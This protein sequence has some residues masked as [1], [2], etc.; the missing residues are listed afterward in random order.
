MDSVI[1]RVTAPTGAQ[2]YIRKNGRLPFWQ[3]GTECRS[4]K[5]WNGAQQ[6]INKKLVGMIQR[7]YDLTPVRT[8]EVV[9]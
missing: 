6:H 8:S 7:G 4:W 9:K 3:S 2:G 1:I 5:T